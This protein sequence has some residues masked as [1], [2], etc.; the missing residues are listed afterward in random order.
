MGALDKLNRRYGEGAVKVG[1]CGLQQAWGM[2]RERKTGAYTT[3]WGELM[4]A[5]A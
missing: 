3:R 4:F 5:Y 1:S 2:K